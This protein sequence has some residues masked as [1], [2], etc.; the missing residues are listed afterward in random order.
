MG[1]FSPQAFSTTAFSI[2]A[3]SLG[4][5]VAAVEGSVKVLRGLRVWLATPDVRCWLRETL[6]RPWSGSRELRAWEA[7]GYGRLWLADAALRATG[8]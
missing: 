8:S 6:P 1:G 7:A 5:L 2:L 3:F 4:A